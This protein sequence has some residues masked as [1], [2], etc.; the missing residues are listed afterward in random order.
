MELTQ[1]LLNGVGKFIIELLHYGAIPGTVFAVVLI[2][3]NDIKDFLRKVKKVKSTNFELSFEDVR[4]EIEKQSSKVKTLYEVNKENFKY[5]HYQTL[6]AAFASSYLIIDAS[7]EMAELKNMAKDVISTTYNKLKR[8]D[9]D[10]AKLKLLSQY[11][12]C[13]K[14]G[15]H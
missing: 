5:V 15:A 7:T 6:L 10:E 12:D 14:R 11:M 2:F 3:K 4:A 13:E 1:F 8:E 9:Y